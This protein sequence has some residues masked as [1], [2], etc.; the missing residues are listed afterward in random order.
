MSVFHSFLMPSVV[1]AFPVRHT[2]WGL[3]FTKCHIL[4]GSHWQSDVFINTPLG[5]HACIYS[6]LC[7]EAKSEFLCVCLNCPCLVWLACGV[8]D[9]VAMK[10]LRKCGEC[11]GYIYVLILE[12]V[13][14]CHIQ[15]C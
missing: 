12:H 8:V 9:Y 7:I 1:F 13:Y 10:Q 4:D 11:Y 6:V 15:Q 14:H 2:C 5:H 3:C